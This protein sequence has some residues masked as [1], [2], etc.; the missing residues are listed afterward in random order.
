M[1]AS[2]ASFAFFAPAYPTY[3]RTTL[4]G[5][6]LINKAPVEKTEYVDELGAK[7]S[8][9]AT[10]IG[11]QSKRRVGL[12]DHSV[13]EAGVTSI[14]T[15]VDLLKKEGFEV[16]IFDV[17]T[18][19]HL[20]DIACSIGDTKLMIGSAGLASELPLG[21]GFCKPKP[22][23]SVCGSTRRLSRTQVRNLRDRLGFREVEIWITRLID[24]EVA[25][26]EEVRRC[27]GESV[28]A[29]KAGVDVSLMSAPKENSV[30]EFV[31][32]AARHG[33]KEVEAK[34]LIEEALGEITS[35][36]LSETEV[37]GLLL[38]GG[39]TGLMVCQK[40][41]AGSASIIEEIEPGIPLLRL[42]TGMPALTK[43][44]GFGVDDS[45]IQATQRM[46]RLMSS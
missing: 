28:E 30:D 8:D 24:G 19:K 31:A 46:R 36:I 39:A 43:A 5:K 38:T 33:I 23:L 7:T 45:L 42:S 37:L 20:I 29:L 9:V 34:H 41:G 27:V 6:Q 13:V 4:S 32:H 35:E 16:A 17:L 14:K 1:E 18:E 22:V 44:G 25:V 40:L 2:K 15:R 12:V 26:K 11:I 21:L 10:I 3:G